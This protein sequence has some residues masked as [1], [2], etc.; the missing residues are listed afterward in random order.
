MG[1]V[2]NFKI[3]SI[4]LSSFVKIGHNICITNAIVDAVACSDL[5]YLMCKT[6]VVLRTSP[7][8]TITLD[9]SAAVPMA[10]QALDLTMVSGNINSKIWT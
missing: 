3:N 4:C 10:Y 8:T 9:E 6:T 5:P 2:T 7:L 1:Q